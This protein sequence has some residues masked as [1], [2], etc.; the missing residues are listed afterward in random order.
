MPFDA[1]RVR[2]PYGGKAFFV[3][4]SGNNGNE[5]SDPEYPLADIVTAIGKCTAGQGDYVFVQNFWEPSAPPVTLNRSGAHLIGLGNGVHGPTVGIDGA[6][7]AAISLGALSGGVEI[8]GFNL[9]STGQADPAILLTDSAWYVHIH[10]NAIGASIAAKDGILVS[11]DFAYAFGSIDH[12]WFGGH[13][14]GWGIYAYPAPSRM[15]RSVILH[16]AF[17][18]TFST[19][20]IYIVGG[21]PEAICWNTF[22]KRKGA[23]EGWAI[24]LYETVVDCMVMGNIAGE[25]GADP[26]HCPYKDISAPDAEKLNY[27]ANNYAGNA[28]VYPQPHA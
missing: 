21:E 5:G 3:H 22:G 16:N 14:S 27:W 20:G 9:G 23:D 13:L 4:A 1:S 10:H 12:N 17:K 2:N 8:A 7:E 25:D 6:G 24:T 19:G 15:T 18:C 11:G 26:G 28:L